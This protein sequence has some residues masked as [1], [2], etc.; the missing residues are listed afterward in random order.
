VAEAPVGKRPP[1]GLDRPVKPW[2]WFAV[3]TAFCVGAFVGTLVIRML[4]S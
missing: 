3:A 1:V 4:G 2:L